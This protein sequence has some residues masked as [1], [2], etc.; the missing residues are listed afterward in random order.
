MTT[1]AGCGSTFRKGKRRA[2]LL[3]SGEIAQRLVC[4]DCAKRAFALVPVRRAVLCTSCPSGDAR[5]A[6]VCGRCSN[7]AA[8]KAVGMA[9]A[10]FVERIRG[11]LTAYRADAHPNAAG[12]EMALDVLESHARRS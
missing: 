7:E 3:P 2:V 10:P 9:L 8:H 5:E 1:C 6:S 4:G 12:L 11:M